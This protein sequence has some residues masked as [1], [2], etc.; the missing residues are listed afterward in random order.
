MKGINDLL[1]GI[2][3]TVTGGTVDHVTAQIAGWALGITVQR[4]ELELTL[5]GSVDLT[6]SFATQD[7]LVESLTDTLAQSL[8]DVELNAPGA[9]PT[10]TPSQDDSSVLA[11]LVEQLLSRLSVNINTLIIHI[12]HDVEYTIRIDKVTYDHGVTISGITV[13]MED[14]SDSDGSVGYTDM[15]MSQAVGDLR[16][17]SATVYASAH[18]STFQPLDP[19]VLEIAQVRHGD[20]R[21]DITHVKGLLHVWQLEALLQAA[22]TLRPAAAVKAAED[23]QDSKD[24]KSTEITLDTLQISLAYQAGATLNFTIKDLKFGE[25]ISIADF[26]ADDHFNG[27]RSVLAFSSSPAIAIYDTITLA[28]SSINVDLSLISR[29]LPLR[30]IFDP[31]LVPSTPNTHSAQPTPAK[32]IRAPS[33]SISII[34]LHSTTLTICITDLAFDGTTIS[35]D[36]SSV[37]CG[38]TFLHINDILFNLDKNICRIPSVRATLDRPTI[39]ALQFLADD[40]SH[41]LVSTKRNQQAPSSDSKTSNS[42]RVVLDNGTPLLC[43]PELTTVDVTLLV[44]SETGSRT[45]G[46]RAGII[47][48]LGVSVSIITADCSQQSISPS[49]ISKWKSSLPSFKA[50]SSFALAPVQPGRPL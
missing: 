42:I 36:S 25:Q 27:I 32:A 17:S 43:Q 7:Y 2:P 13:R 9:F 15:L 29:L 48:D 21:V 47:A 39:E 35:L 34:P 37:S 50:L 11:G 26:A 1:V 49:M 30:Y 4:L 23:L 33:I 44:P 5:G 46:V 24:V 45:V 38:T 12:S 14:I 28:P 16:E 31:I 40:V 41:W 19:P 6:Q 8:A 3:L 22:R 20:G 18:A 10:D